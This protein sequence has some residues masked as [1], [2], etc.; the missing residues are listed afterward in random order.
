MP[1]NKDHYIHKTELASK[2]PH[3]ADLIH[4]F[5]FNSIAKSTNKSYNSHNNNYLNWCLKNNEFPIYPPNET[6]LMFYIVDRVTTTKIAIK[7]AKAALYSIRWFSIYNGFDCD[8]KKMF[9]LQNTIHG[10]K[11]VLGVNDADKRLPI[12]VS[13]L[14][15]FRRRMDLSNYDELVIFTAMVVATFGLLRTGEFAVDSKKNFEPEKLLR[16]SSLT[17]HNDKKGK[18]KFFTLK[19]KTSKTD[20]FRSGVTITL[21]HGFEDID[22]VNLLSR[23]ILMREKEAKKNKKLKLESEKPL[24]CLKNGTPLSRWDVSTILKALT[25]KCNL[26]PKRYKGQSFRIGG[27]TSYA[28]RGYPSNIIQIMGRWKSD[29]YKLYTRF[30]H[31]DLADLQKEMANADIVNKNIVF[32]YQRQAQSNLSIGPN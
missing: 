32:L 6:R 17:A 15:R 21:G 11:K 4:F 24:F 2:L 26:D 18:V 12:T 13:L 22:P 28:R 7:T 3:T 10:M 20:I 9:R 14:K 19:L 29:C 30:S 31:Q 1:K 8:L 16:I 25:T 5:Q 23:M 27:A